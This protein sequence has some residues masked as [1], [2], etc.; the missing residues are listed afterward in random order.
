MTIGVADAGAER[1]PPRVR[2]GREKLPIA[3]IGG[4][5]SGTMAAIEL[6]RSVPPDQP[7]LLCERGQTF[8][9]GVAYATKV[10]EHLLNVRATNMSAFAS[11]PAHFQSWLVKQGDA[12]GAEVHRT[13]AG[14]FATRD[15]Y[16]KYLTSILYDA[17]CRDDSAGQLRLLPD[18]I[19]DCAVIEGGFEL[20][21]GSGRRYRVAAVVLATGHV[22]PVPSSDPRYVNNPWAP[23]ALRGFERATPVLV[24]GTALTMVDVVLALR[25]EGF[26][27]P[28]IALSRG[29]LLPQA[30]AATEAWPM[31][32]FTEAELASVRLV[33][34]RLRAEA[35][36]ART[37]GVDWRAVI[38]SIRPI[39]QEL[40]RGWSKTERRRFVRHAR[41]W[42]D[43]HRHRM[44]PPNAAMVDRMLR[45][46]GLRIVSGRIGDVTF[47]DAAVRVTYEP[48]GGGALVELA[49]QRVI[50]ATGLESAAKT[51]DR[52][53][54][55][56][57]GQHLLRWDGLGF[58]VDVTMD[59]QVVGADGAPVPRLWALG[60]LVRGVFWECVAVP[61]I[62]LQADRLGKLVAAALETTAAISSAP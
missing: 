5:F 2:V 10:S 3:V 1:A 49:V 17:V 35:A 18:D 26:A 14:V 24:L 39:T 16:G 29:G 7:I 61:D 56:L 37:L 21:S 30:H 43:I 36:M 52:L 22:P 31:P 6:A 42:W 8:G 57:I 27:G 4:G 12:V 62:R 38:D 59:L 19:V 58:G 13:E 9:S 23:G 25:R 15:T 11:E 41:R 20:T 28:V 54:R 50:V 45:E 55:R 48:R 34:R 60:P 40:W 47:D 46:G 51:N 33:M 44:A 32:S 53:M